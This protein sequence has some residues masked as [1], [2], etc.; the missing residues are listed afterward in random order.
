MTRESSSLVRMH[1]PSLRLDIFIQSSSVY[2]V[3]NANDWDA[4]LHSRSH[5]NAV[6]ALSYLVPTGHPVERCH[7]RRPL[8]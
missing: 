3:L 1:S 2:V 6:Q 5:S 4:I 7:L 8:L